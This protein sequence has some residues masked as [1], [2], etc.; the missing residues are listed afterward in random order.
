MNTKN[1]RTASVFALAGLLM[2]GASFASVPLYK[3]FCQL[4]GY[5]GT[6]RQAENA[7]IAP[8]VAGHPAPIFEIRFDANTAPGLPWQFAPAQT[9]LRVK[10]GAPQTTYY[11]AKNT[12]DESVIGSAIFNVTPLKIGAYFVKMECFCF[13]EHTLAPGEEASMP[14]TFLV[15]PAIMDDPNAREVDTITLSY[16]FYRQDSYALYGQDGNGSQLQ[17]N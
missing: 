5:G 3:L 1:K 13:I 8:S 6:P 15:D 11:K 7:A 17:A 4:T 14:V 16:T 9:A 2:L 12:S 10:L